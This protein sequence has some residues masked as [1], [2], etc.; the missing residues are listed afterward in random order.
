V[1]RTTSSLWS[2]L[3]GAERFAENLGIGLGCCLVFGSKVLMNAPIVARTSLPLLPFLRMSTLLLLITNPTTSA[4]ARER[5]A[6]KPS[7]PQAPAPF[8]SVGVARALWTTPRSRGLL[9]QRSCA[10]LTRAV[11]WRR[12][13]TKKTTTKMNATGSSCLTVTCQTTKESMRMWVV[14]VFAFGNSTGYKAKKR[15]GLPP[16]AVSIY[17]YLL[18]ARAVCVWREL[19]L[20]LYRLNEAHNRRYRLQRVDRPST[21]GVGNLGPA[22]YDPHQNFPYPSWSATS[23]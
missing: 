13:K 18:R 3:Q 17:F 16:A 7:P 5:P 22:W 10:S 4:F 15:P 20:R 6:L 23:R 21:P 11:T 2:A 14:F 1:S 19:L 9:A 8:S 12:K